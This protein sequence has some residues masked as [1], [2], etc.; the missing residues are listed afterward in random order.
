[1]F[2]DKNNQYW[3][4]NILP[5]AIYRFNA[6]LVK[7][8]WYFFTDL[9]SIISQFVWK[10]KKPLIA[11]K[12]LRKKNRSE[13]ITLPDFVCCKAALTSTVWYRHKDRS[14]EQ[15]SKIESP[16]INPCTYGHCI[17][18]KGGKNAQWKKDNLTS[19]AGQTGQ[20]PKIMKLEHFLTPYTKNILN[21]D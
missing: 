17:F 15:Q 1:M 7:L 8:K 19:D 16:E 4:M 20:P 2:M 6:M 14:I 3:E 12:V 5:K 9:E 13:G 21:M 11:E 18:G 10:H